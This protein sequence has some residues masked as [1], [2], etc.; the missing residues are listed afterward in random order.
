MADESSLQATFDRSSWLQ[1]PRRLVFRCLLGFLGGNDV[2]AGFDSVFISSPSSCLDDM[3]SQ[4]SMSEWR[5]QKYNRR[6]VSSSIDNT[7]VTSNNSNTW[8][9]EWCV[10]E[11]VGLNNPSFKTTTVVP[12]S[13]MESRAQGQYDIKEYVVSK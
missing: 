7:T 11:V 6:L 9:N 10:V 8:T 5:F 2:P 3:L 12:T 4:Q 13:A 1:A